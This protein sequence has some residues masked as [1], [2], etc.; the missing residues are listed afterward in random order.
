MIKALKEG[1][2]NCSIC[3]IKLYQTAIYFAL[4]NIL[5]LIF[6]YFW[7]FSSRCFHKD[8]LYSRLCKGKILVE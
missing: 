1:K 7:N 4:T 3:R 6:F 5:R 8:Y 2:N